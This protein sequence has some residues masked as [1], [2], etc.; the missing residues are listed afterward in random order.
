MQKTPK[1][2]RIAYFGGEPLGVPVLEELKL[3]GITPDLIVSSPDKPVGRKQVMSAPPVKNWAKA[4]CVE[5]FQPESYKDEVIRAYFESKDWDVF[6]VVAYNFILPQWL[7]DIPK[8]GVINV[9]PSM[10]PMLRGASPIRTA[11]KDDLREAIGVTIMQMDEEMDHGPI[12]DQMPMDIA[13]ENWPV[14]GPELDLALARMGGA[15]LADTLREYL[16]GY[17]EPQ[18][19]EH[20]MATYCGRF[21][22]SD[23]ELEINPFKLPTSNKARLAWLK[24]NAFIGIGDTFF[25]HDGKRIKIKE[26]EFT[27]GKLRLTTVIPEGKS[28]MPFENWLETVER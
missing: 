22:K 23:S 13:D 24:I 17:I 26:A 4:E 7:L 6:I 21:Q 1:R 5:V 25:M 2:N 10:L 20:D 12:L 11:I 27:M 9:H 8:H 3:S 14:P 16:A 19:Q 28:A 15:M 18:E